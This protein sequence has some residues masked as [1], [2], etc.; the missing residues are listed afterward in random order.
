MYLCVWPTLRQHNVHACAEL[1]F[2]K[3]KSLF[4]LQAASSRTPWSCASHHH[5]RFQIP[6]AAAETHTSRNSKKCKMKPC[7]RC[8]YEERNIFHFPFF[9]GGSGA[10]VIM[11][12]PALFLVFYSFLPT[13]SPSSDY[14]E[15]TSYWDHQSFYFFLTLSLPSQLLV[16]E[17]RDH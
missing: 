10:V 5:V 16:Q 15:G 12:H 2:W 8:S 13:F 6:C 11:P 7:S 14:A 9:C 3:L 17:F 4:L 1:G